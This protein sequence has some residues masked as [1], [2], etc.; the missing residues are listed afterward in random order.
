MGDVPRS[1]L[2]A[3]LAERAAILKLADVP[4]DVVE[5]AR[6]ALLDWFAVTL[7][8]S[9]EPA[10]RLVRETVGASG[11]GECTVVGRAG[12]LPAR[13]AALVNGT[14]SHALDFDDVNMRVVCHVSAAVV[15]AALAL[16]E[17]LDASGE[18]LLAAYVAGYETA[19]RVA[20]AIGP[21][22]YLRGFHA[23]GTVGAFGA[24]AA[25]AR[26]LG[27]DPG[28]T[29]RALGIAASGAAGVKR[30]FGTMTKPLHAGRACE[31][32]LLAAELAGRGF[33]A[34]T[35]A[36]EADQG[37]AAICGGGCDSEAALADPPAGWHLRENLFK[38][39][40]ACYYAHSA[41]EGVSGLREEH[42][43]T[44]DRVRAIRLRIGAS[45]RGACTIAAPGTGLEVKFSIAHLAAMALLGRDTVLIGDE[46]ARDEEAIAARGLVEL[47]DGKPDGAPT[48]VEIVLDDGTELATERDVN[49]P[50]TDPTRRSARLERKYRALAEPVLGRE[51][52]ERLRALLEGCER[53]R[54]RELAAAAAGDA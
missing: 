36:I 1:G 24:A 53:A 7:A 42:G 39:H 20:V 54:V 40:A 46:A 13:D 37:F 11:A 44:A 30:N 31:T 41:I 18:E 17:R 45:E 51:A 35:D 29:A 23:T 26:L 25:C 47:L 19:S 3:K 48:R 5:L 9:A 4:E 14:A 33:T 10:A 21:E 49:S 6:H 38:F 22:P 43:L 16:G 2:T 28:A 50:E 34:A 15:G 12:R 8:G 27:L 52:S 32:G